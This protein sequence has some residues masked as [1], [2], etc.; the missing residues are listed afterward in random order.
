MYCGTV[1]ITGIPACRLCILILM[2]I[3]GGFR[4]SFFFDPRYCRQCLLTLI[5]EACFFMW[6]AL[7]AIF[8]SIFLNHKHLVT[9]CD[10]QTVE[11]VEHG[12]IKCC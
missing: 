9:K 6:I 8:F 2:N 5:L 7:L 3:G 10:R 1:A 11:R 12:I 4:R